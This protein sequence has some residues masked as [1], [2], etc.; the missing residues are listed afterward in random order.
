MLDVFRILINGEVTEVVWTELLKSTEV[1]LTDTS[2][3]LHSQRIPVF[4]IT[5]KWTECC[6]PTARRVGRAAPQAHTHFVQ[7]VC[8]Q[9]SGLDL[10]AVVTSDSHPGVAQCQD[11]H[12]RSHCTVHSAIQAAKMIQST[13]RVL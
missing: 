13:H 1:T 7:V 3:P 8:S 9:S 12:Q 5:A 4:N 6:V 11:Q 2:P 10:V